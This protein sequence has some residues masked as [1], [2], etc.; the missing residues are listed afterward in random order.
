MQGGQ[1]ND[2]LVIALEFNG[3][4]EHDVLDAREWADQRVAGWLGGEG[5]E[6]DAGIRRVVTALL[7]HVSLEANA[8]SGDGLGGPVRHEAKVHAPYHEGRLTTR[9]F[10]RFRR[11]GRVGG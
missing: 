1:I 6:R 4:V 3:R 11:R 7:T 2:S 9:D 8:E 5:D 10:P